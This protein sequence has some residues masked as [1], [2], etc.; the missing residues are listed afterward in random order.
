[1]SFAKFNQFDHFSPIWALKNEEKDKISVHFKQIRSRSGSHLSTYGIILATDQGKIEKKGSFKMTF[2]TLYHSSK[3]IWD[4]TEETLQNFSS[5]RVLKV[6]LN[7]HILAAQGA[8][9]GNM[10]F[11]Q[12]GLSLPSDFV[13]KLIF[14]PSGFS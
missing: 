9:E 11:L 12:S 5:I 7:F 14:C 13:H 6:V 2:D 4:N 3:K 1:M 10:Y 8:N